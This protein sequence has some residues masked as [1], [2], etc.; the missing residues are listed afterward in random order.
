[1]DQV[2]L[3]LECRK[4]N[5]KTVLSTLRLGQ[6]LHNYTKLGLPIMSQSMYAMAE[7]VIK[8]MHGKLN[9]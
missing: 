7:S 8:Y 2:W 9:S 1:M 3:I 4:V 5:R 6:F